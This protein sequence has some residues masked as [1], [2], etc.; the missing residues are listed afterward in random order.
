CSE[1]ILD[2]DMVLRVQKQSESSGWDSGPTEHSLEF[3]FKERMGRRSYISNPTEPGYPIIEADVRFSLFMA[4]QTADELRLDGKLDEAFWVKQPPRTY[5]RADVARG[6][7]HLEGDSDL[8]V[9]V[10]MVWRED[11]LVV[12][13]RIK[14]DVAM[15]AGCDAP[16]NWTHADRVELWLDTAKSLQVSGN[17]AW[18]EE[19]RKIYL[20][21][22]IR[23]RPD[24]TVLSFT[25][26]RSAEGACVEQVL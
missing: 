10:R 26:A 19:H 15:R 11:A 20:E 12:G 25:L 17:G 5:G 6:R 13:L 7:D 18:V 24:N 23:H 8:S 16:K 3:D 22:P 9:D 2:A 1:V 4:A 21:D 14:D